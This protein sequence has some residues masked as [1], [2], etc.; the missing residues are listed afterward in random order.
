MAIQLNERDELIFSL[1]EEHE[2]LLEKHIAWF[3]SGDQKPVLIRDRLRKLFY[4]DYL[5]CQRHRD[6][7]PWWTTP[8][9][10]LVY[11]LSPMTRE[12]VGAGEMTIDLDDS[13]MHRHL[14]EVANLRMLFLQDQKEGHIENLQWITCK[15][16]KGGS[17]NLDAKVTFVRNGVTHSIGIINHPSTDIVMAKAEAAAGLD[18]VETLWIVSRDE[19]HQEKLQ[20][21]MATSKVNRNCMFATHQDLYKLG[22]VKCNWENSEQHLSAMFLDSVHESGKCW[23]GGFGMTQAA[24]A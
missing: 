5:L 18:D 17:K 8:T 15:S 2:V 24:T 20:K 1:I 22:I 23:N 13:N 7:L 10:P 19:M 16:Q 12:I 11:T 9:K 3:I 6:T 4:L 14:L 21:A